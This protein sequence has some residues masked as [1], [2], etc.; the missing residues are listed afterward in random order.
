V[1]RLQV[2]VFLRER[3]RLCPCQFVVVLGHQ[4]SID[5][6]LGGGES[7]G[8]NKVERGVSNELAP[9]PEERLLEVVI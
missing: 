2:V 5:R 1:K 7:W 8:R 6:D 3:N 4:G 9:E